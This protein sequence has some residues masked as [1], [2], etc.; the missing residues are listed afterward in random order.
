MTLIEIVNTFNYLGLHF[1]YN[2]KYTVAEKQLAEQRRNASFALSKQI[3]D[4][5]L[6]VECTIFLFDTFISSMIMRPSC[7]VWIKV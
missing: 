7:G 6:N 4:M 2:G 5:Y 1:N 3:K